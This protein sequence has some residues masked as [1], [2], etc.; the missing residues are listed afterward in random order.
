MD[1]IG[2]LR[3]VTA[4]FCAASGLSVEQASWR[5]FVDQ[6]RLGRVFAGEAGL[7]VVSLEKAAQWFAANWPEGAAWPE[8]GFARIAPETADGPSASGARHDGAHAH[9]A[10]PEILP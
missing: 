6:K 1:L 2:Q 9:P 5:I 4:A 3:I 10:T 7:T 8:G